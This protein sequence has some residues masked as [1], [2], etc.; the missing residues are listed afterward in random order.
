M[1]WLPD[2]SIGVVVLS[3]RGSTNPIPSMIVQATYDRLLGLEPLDHAARQRKSDADDARREDSTKTA[4]AAE[5]KA[6]TSPSHPLGDYVGRY[7]H[8]GYGT[9]EIRQAPNG[10]EI[11]LD[12][13][14]AKLEHYHYDTFRATES[15]SLVPFTG[16]VMFQ[17]NAKGMVD[18]V[19]VPVEQPLP[20]IAF[21]RAPWHQ[22]FRRIR[23]AKVAV[24]YFDA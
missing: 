5:R 8:P 23:S 13:I 6:G 20:A 3:N 1:S 10:L 16:L 14:G 12:A 18:R 9:V 19:L 22:L 2:D 4:L 24:R 17:S 11:A 7:T 21:T 15:A